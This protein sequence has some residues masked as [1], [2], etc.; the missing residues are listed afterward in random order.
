MI[1]VKA[2]VEPRLIHLICAVAN[3]GAQLN[4]DPVITAG[5]DG[6]HMKGSLHY[7]YRAIDIRT[8]NLKDKQAFFLALKSNLGPDYD[9]VFE[10][11]NLPIE[12][13]HAEYD[14]SH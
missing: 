2:G 13:I 10:S 4:E 14:P 5:C 3:V 8:H 9:V 1:S 7:R 12:H 11:H 6:Q